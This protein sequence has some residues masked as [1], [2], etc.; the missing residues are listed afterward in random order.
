M[1]NKG[2]KH[3]PREKFHPCPGA[4]K[5][6]VLLADMRGRTGALKPRAFHARLVA[7]L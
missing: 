2:R 7:L 1:R 3:L 6:K 4:L 5:R